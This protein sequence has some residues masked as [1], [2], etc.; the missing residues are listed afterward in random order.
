MHA[1]IS[2]QIGR[3]LHAASHAALRKT[4]PTYAF[5]PEEFFD[6]DGFQRG[7]YLVSQWPSINC[8]ANPLAIGSHVIPD[9]ENPVNIRS[10]CPVLA[11]FLRRIET[12]A[13]IKNQH[14][15]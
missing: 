6:A 1:I 7:R 2:C 3:V 10:R 13:A 8:G 14:A 4:R 15:A 9:P 5:I 12:I 11:E